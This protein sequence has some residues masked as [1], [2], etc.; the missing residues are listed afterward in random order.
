MKIYKNEQAEWKSNNRSPTHHKPRGRTP[1]QY[2]HFLPTTWQNRLR[3]FWVELLVP[4]T[5]PHTFLG[6]VLVAAPYMFLNVR[7][8]DNIHMQN[9]AGCRVRFICLNHSASQ[10]QSN[11]E[12]FLSPTSS[13][14]MLR[15]QKHR[16]HCYVCVLGSWEGWEHFSWVPCWREIA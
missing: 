15:E 13:L 2:P 5:G 1:S 7:H 10:S 14:F 8:L 12:V 16:C 3:L 4:R 9:L 6:Q 11:W